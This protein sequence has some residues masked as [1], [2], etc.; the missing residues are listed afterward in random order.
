MIKLFNKLGR[1]ET[2]LTNL[3]KQAIYKM[4]IAN[5]ILNDGRLNT[6]LERSRTRQE[7]CSYYFYLTLN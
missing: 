5:I 3:Q 2:F 6:L 4:S 7:V 1:E